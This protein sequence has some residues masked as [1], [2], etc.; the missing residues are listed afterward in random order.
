MY[1]KNILKNGIRVMMEPIPYVQS[2]SIGFWIRAGSLY[3]TAH[4]NGV[5]HF[6]EHMLF[7]GTQNR[8]AKQIAAEIDDLGGELNAFTSKECTCVYVKVL[9]EHAPVAIEIISDMMLHSTFDDAELQKERMIILDEINLYEDSAEDLI[10]DRLSEVIFKG[11]ALGRPI[12]GSSES[13]EGIDRTLMTD[14]FK[15]HY[16]AQNLVIS[17]AGNYDEASLLT[18]LD[19]GIGSHEFESHKVDKIKPIPFHSGSIRTKKDIEQTH[20]ILGFKSVGYDTPELFTLM[21]LNNA[22]GG[23]S[24]SRLFQKIREDYGL[25]YSIDSHPSFYHDTGI[26][27]V[28]ASML[29]ENVEKVVELIAAEIEDLRSNGLD[30]SEFIKFKNQLK[31]N[32]LLGMEGPTQTMNWIGKSELLSGHIRTIEDVMAGIMSIEFDAVNDLAKALLSRENMAISIVGKTSAK[33]EKRLYQILKEII[34]G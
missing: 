10:Y 4:E 27:T 29:P 18:L 12:L 11:H 24:S 26:L 5:S 30:Q 31:G 2:V 33:E 14:Y 20:V 8:S 6:I 28:Y 3:E 34:K 7:K 15:R 1:K 13:I 25:S 16:N 22:L 21:L 17:I 9:G 23:S 19:S 32:F